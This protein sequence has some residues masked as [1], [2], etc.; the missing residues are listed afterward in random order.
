MRESARQ[1]GDGAGGSGATDAGPLDD[2]TPPDP[3]SPLGKNDEVDTDPASPKARAARSSDPSAEGANAADDKEAVTPKE[4]LGDVAAYDAPPPGSPEDD[5]VELLL[6]AIPRK[7]P[8]PPAG[9]PQSDG[10]DTAAYHGEHRI[11]A[12][13]A[14]HE[15]DAKVVVA[16]P[17][18][19]PLT[20]TMRIVRAAPVASDRARRTAAEAAASGPPSVVGRAGLAI[21]AALAVVAALFVVLRTMARRPVTTAAS[22]TQTLTATPILSPTPALALTPTLTLTQTPTPALTQTPTLTP[23]PSQTPAPTSR[24]NAASTSSTRAPRTKPAPPPSVPPGG[25][26]GEFKTTFQ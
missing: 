11:P 19:T 6:G 10:K 7:P 13:Q 8:L 26:L 12:P 1:P 5:S 25:E 9:L 18:L 17:P 2:S 22:P 4:S 14:L 3:A 16:G 23:T 20:Q 15:E 21:V 24:T